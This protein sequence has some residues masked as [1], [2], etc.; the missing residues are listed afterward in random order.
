MS[1]VHS[2][3]LT[4]RQ[5]EEL[6]ALKAMPDEEI[7]YSD[8]PPTTAEQWNRAEVGRFYHPAKEQLTLQVDADVVAWFKAQGKDYPVRINELLRQ[9]MLREAQHS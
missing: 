3:K 4:Q 5:L 9:V 1:K 2:T 6:E 8:I 7:D